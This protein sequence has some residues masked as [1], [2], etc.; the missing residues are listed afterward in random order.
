MKELAYLTIK[1]ASARIVLYGRL[2][3]YKIIQNTGRA[4]WNMKVLLKPTTTLSL[5]LS[6]CNKIAIQNCWW[7]AEFPLADLEKAHCSAWEPELRAH[8]VIA[9]WTVGKTCLRPVLIPRST[10]AERDNRVIQIAKDIS[11]Q[12]SGHQF[13]NINSEDVGKYA[14]GERL[15]KWGHESS[16]C[17]NACEEFRETAWHW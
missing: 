14:K 6:L 11:L 10:S 5:S 1:V 17:C 7:A 13:R 4:T 16:D 2:P 12:S 3:H 9:L 8:T 15:W